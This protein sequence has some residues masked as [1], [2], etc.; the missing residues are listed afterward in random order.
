MNT[1]YFVLLITY[2]YKYTIDRN[3]R[4]ELTQGYNLFHLNCKDKLVSSSKLEVIPKRIF[5]IL[6]YV[7]YILSLVLK[8]SIFQ[9]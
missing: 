8:Y 5:P 2:M 9:L 6:P 3:F 1:K 4:R 7:V